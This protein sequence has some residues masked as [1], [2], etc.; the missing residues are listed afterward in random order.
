MSPWEGAPHIIENVALA[1][2]VGSGNPGRKA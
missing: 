1:P 2:G